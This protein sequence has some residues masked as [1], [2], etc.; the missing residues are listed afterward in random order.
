MCGIQ[1]WSPNAL[2][3]NYL[4][5]LYR[6][7]Y[8]Y[9]EDN[10]TIKGFAQEHTQDILEIGKKRQKEEQNQRLEKQRQIDATKAERQLQRLIKKIYK[11]RTSKFC[12]EIHKER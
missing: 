12:Y 7:A 5:C 2:G 8:L 1:R 9:G 3:V 11:Q 6:C 10:V 4:F